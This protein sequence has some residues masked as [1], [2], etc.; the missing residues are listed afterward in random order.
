ME[1]LIHWILSSL[2]ILVAA[3]IMPGVMVGGF[4]VALLAA[5]VIGIINAVIKP[6]LILFTLPIN[7]LTLGLFTLV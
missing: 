6:L 1:I 4:L 5:V 2:V 7:I 3:Y